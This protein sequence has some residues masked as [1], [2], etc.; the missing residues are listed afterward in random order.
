MKTILTS[1]A[2]FLAVALALVGCSSSSSGNDTGAGAGGSGT[3]G[4][5]TAGAGGAGTAGAGTAGA[6]T[7]GAGTA[8]TAGAGTAGMAGAGTAGSAG[9][10]GGAGGTAGAGGGATG[11]AGGAASAPKCADYCAAVQKNC[12]GDKADYTSPEACA[13]ICA[14]LPVGAIADTSGDTVGCR[15]YHANAAAS[16]ATLHCP[17]AGLEGGGV[18]GTD[19]C[20][21]FCEGVKTVCTGTLAPYASDADCKTACGKFAVGSGPLAAATSGDTLLCRVYHLEA[22]AVSATAAMTHCAHTGA[23]SA[24]CK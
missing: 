17:H 13:A 2:T 10:G 19:A 22:A 23:V 5:G 9:A 4:S 3:A 21:A 20:T 7:A 12:T 16:D 8:G 1:K 14:G 6:G 11:G 15:L 24:V 18:C